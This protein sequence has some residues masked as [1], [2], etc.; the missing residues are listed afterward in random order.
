MFKIINTLAPFFEEPV[1]EFNVRE[2][3]R[4]L[5]IS[6]ATASKELMLRAK[7]GILRGRKERNLLLYKANLDGQPYLDLKVYYTLR[8]IKESGLV[9]ELNRFYLKPTIVLFGS[10]ARGLDTETSD[11]DVLIISEKTQEFLNVKKYEKKLSRK[12]QFFVVKKVQDL[13]NEHLINN[14]L[15]GIV[16]QGAVKWI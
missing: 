7:E 2:V 3:S 16:V 11:I 10:C 12:L 1:R 6:P 9:E 14:V 8:K 13:K 5:H 15:N 4:I